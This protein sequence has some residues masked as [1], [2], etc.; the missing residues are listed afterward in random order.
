[1]EFDNPHIIIDTLLPYLNL[2]IQNDF[3]KEMQERKGQNFFYSNFKINRPTSV[4]FNV[5]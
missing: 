2:I 4:A 5:E 3:C 1:M